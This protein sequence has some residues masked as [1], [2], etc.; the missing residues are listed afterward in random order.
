MT[1]K[2]LSN[3]FN[4]IDVFVQKRTPNNSVVLEFGFDVGGVGFEQGPYI[5]GWKRM[6]MQNL[7]STHWSNIVNVTNMTWPFE[8]IWHMYTQIFDNRNRFDIMRTKVKY[9]VSRRFV[10]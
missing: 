9:I 1:R 6:P 3:R 7:N 8:I 10:R 4:K 5:S 2:F